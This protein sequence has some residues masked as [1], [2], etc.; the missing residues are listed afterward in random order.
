MDP[1]GGL[2]WTCGAGSN[3]DLWACGAG[4]DGPVTVGMWGGCDGPVKR[5]PMDLCGPAPMERRAL[6]DL[7]GGGLMICNS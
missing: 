3:V 4:S 5:A 7:I 2:R 1:W 6:L